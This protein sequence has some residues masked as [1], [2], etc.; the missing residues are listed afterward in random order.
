MV[1]PALSRPRKS[2]LACLFASPS[3]AS[4]SQTIQQRGS[5]Q[6]LFF[7]VFGRS[8][9]PWVCAIAGWRFNVHQ[10]RIHILFLL[11]FDG[12][13]GGICCMQDRRGGVGGAYFLKGDATGG[14]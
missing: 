2:S 12:E 8:T 7:I 5:H 13:K 11:L 14:R 3:W 10:S 6:L 9:C 1:L 4:M